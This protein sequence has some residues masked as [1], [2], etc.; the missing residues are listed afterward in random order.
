MRTF[1]ILILHFFTTV[2]K[3][4]GS[5]GVKAIIAENLIIKQQLIVLNRPRKK[6]P[7]LTTLERITFALLAFVV[8]PKRILKSCVIFK[9]QTWLD[10]RNYLVKRKYSKL[11]SAKQ[12][13]K[14]GPKGPS[15]ELID[16]IIDI[17]KENPTFGCPRIANFLKNNFDEPVDKDIV[18]R[19]L[20]KYHKYHPPEKGRGP[21]WLTLLGHTKDSLWSLDFF[22]CES[23]LLQSYWIMV[24][25]DQKTRRI[26]G[27]AVNR[28]AMTAENAVEMF[29]EIAANNPNPIHL[30]TDN[31]P[32]FKAYLWKFVLSCCEIDEVKSVPHQ[33]WTHPFIERLIRS[34]RNEYMDKLFFWNIVDLKN[35]LI[36]Y[37][38]YY[39]NARVHEALNGGIPQHV[40]DGSSIK[41]A[42]LKNY[43]YHSYC[44]GLF[45]I[46]FAA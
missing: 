19:V 44:R 2:A 20:D 34:I 7:S 22:R 31:D 35:K 13:A 36:S 21:S 1:L 26:V 16:A 3:L 41:I 42:D 17:K 32:L 30:S 24:V 33:P 8:T 43:R 9:P 25:L 23:I 6:G 46:P 10:F 11:F 28:G 27:F 12:K 4:I 14:P 45:K 29:F 37:Q 40:A 38:E 18:R 15:Q 39:N 5:G